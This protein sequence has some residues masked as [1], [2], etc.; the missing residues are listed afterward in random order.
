[1]DCASTNRPKAEAEKVVMGSLTMLS[2]RWW[3]WVTPV[4]QSIL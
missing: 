4:R 3:V 2:H 1:M